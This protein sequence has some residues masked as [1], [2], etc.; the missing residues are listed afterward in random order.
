MPQKSTIVWVPKKWTILCVPKKRYMKKLRALNMANICQQDVKTLQKF[1]IW[2]VLLTN[3]HHLQG[4]FWPFT[5]DDYTFWW[6]NK[7]PVLDRLKNLCMRRFPIHILPFSQNVYEFGIVFWGLTDV[8]LV[9]CCF[10]FLCSSELFNIL[11]VIQVWGRTDA[12]GLRAVF[13]CKWDWAIRVEMLA[14]PVLFL[15]STKRFD[16]YIAPSFSLELKIF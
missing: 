3:I 7:M 5:L 8:P 13:F 11:K 15:T 2:Y 16:E 9:D 1:F 6:R 4:P 14:L 10:R 12:Q